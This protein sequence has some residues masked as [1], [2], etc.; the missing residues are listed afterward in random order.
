MAAKRKK[1]EEA[2]LSKETDSKR[3]A[4]KAKKERLASRTAKQSQ[5]E[6]LEKLRVERERAVAI[7]AKRKTRLAS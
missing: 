4:E 7:D 6:K 1:E 3:S 5:Q 2:R